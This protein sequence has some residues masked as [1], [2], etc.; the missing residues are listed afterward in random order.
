GDYGQPVLKETEDE[1]GQLIDSYNA[2]VEGLKERDFIRNTF[3][4]YVDKEFA[5][6]LLR[7]PEMADLGGQKREGVILMSDLRGFTPLAEALNPEMI[8]RI[9]NH[10]FSYM[11]RVINQHRGIVVDL[12]GDMVLVFFDPLDGP[13]QSAAVNAVRCAFDMQ[14]EMKKFN[15]EIKQEK[16]ADIEMGIGINAG[17]VVVGNIGSETRAKFSIIGSA[18]N[19]T[20]RIQ[21][22]AKPREILISDSVYTY[23]KEKVTVIRSFK[24]NLKGIKDVLKLYSIGTL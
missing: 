13:I 15:N 20:D 14:D 11:I 19:I 7:H 5:Q 9:L 4:R 24:S 23:V 21:S 18:V 22:V 8:I 16:L 10:Y 3:G 12:V 17:P 1:I 6:K 2:M